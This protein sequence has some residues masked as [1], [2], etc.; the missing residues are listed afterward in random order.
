MKILKIF[1]RVLLL[2]LLLLLTNSDKNIFVVFLETSFGLSFTRSSWA[3]TVPNTK[4][5]KEK[6][7][8]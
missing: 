3:T 4:A 6:D 8:E 1:M 2:L 5:P 7:S